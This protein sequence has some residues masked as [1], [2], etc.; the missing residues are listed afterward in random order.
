MRSVC[1]AVGIKQ[2]SSSRDAADADIVS[3]LCVAAGAE[4]APQEREKGGVAA[5][6]SLFIR[7][8]FAYICT[9]VYVSLGVCR[10]IGVEKIFWPRAG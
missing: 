2:C 1:Y 8:R 3:G 10:Y 9:G 5:R 6:D 4:A 7:T